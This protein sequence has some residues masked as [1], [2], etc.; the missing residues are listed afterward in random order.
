[1]LEGFWRL[2]V[3]AGMFLEVAASDNFFSVSFLALPRGPVPPGSCSAYLLTDHSWP[4]P[5]ADS[6][7][8]LSYSDFPSATESCKETGVRC[9]YICHQKKPALRKSK[10]DKFPAQAIFWQP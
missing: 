6:S 7:L 2:E 9:G 4:E 8:F 5:H 10:G 3:A 1:M